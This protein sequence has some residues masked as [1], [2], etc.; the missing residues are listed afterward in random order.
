[1]WPS[2]TPSFTLIRM[3]YPAFSTEMALVQFRSPPC[4]LSSLEPKLQPWAWPLFFVYLR[5]CSAPNLSASLNRN[6]LHL[7]YSYYCSTL[8][9]GH[10]RSSPLP[11]FFGEKIIWDATICHTYLNYLK[12]W[13]FCFQKKSLLGLISDRL[14][15]RSSCPAEAV[16]GAVSLWLWE[17][18]FPKG[19]AEPHCHLNPSAYEGWVWREMCTV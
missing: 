4:L 18:K 1:M 7:P 5:E 14:L 2:L 13:R 12:F 10:Q 3:W 9:S 19:T 11:S 8:N 6:L 15:P 17:T 16:V